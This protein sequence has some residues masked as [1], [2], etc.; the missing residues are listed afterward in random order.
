M[1]SRFLFGASLL[2]LA[3]AMATPAW[4]ADATDDALA[5]ATVSSVVVTA[6]PDADQTQLPVKKATASRPRPSPRRSTP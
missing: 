1:P 3:A 4:S 6:T 2:A 5:D